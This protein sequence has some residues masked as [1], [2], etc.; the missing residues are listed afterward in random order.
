MRPGAGARALPGSTAVLAA[1]CTALVVLAG[2]GIRTTSVPVDDGPAPSR[3]ACAPP[4]VAATPAPESMVEKVYLLC[5]AQVAPVKRTVEVRDARFDRLSEVR[6]LLAQLQISPRTAETKAGF[7]T[8]IP[9][10]LEIFTA[11]PGDGR[12]A[13]RLNDRPE[14]LPSFA[15]AQLVCT[16]AADPLV[17]P[18]HAVVLGGPEPDGGLRSY[19][20]T[21]DLRTRSDAA[22]AA[23]TPVG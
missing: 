12:D 1:S 10:T 22:D 7:S 5:N 20:C 16:L 23:G 15:L 13:L 18:D 4:K 3:V 14:D 9:G 11:G 2:C 17:A 6:T 21:S 19:T 8:A